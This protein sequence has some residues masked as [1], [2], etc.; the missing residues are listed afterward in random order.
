MPRDLAI[1]D[2]G[3]IIHIGLDNPETLTAYAYLKDPGA[4]IQNIPIDQ[5]DDFK[6]KY[7][8]H[9]DGTVYLVRIMDKFEGREK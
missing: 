9:T 6:R 1:F 8:R 4:A 7:F 3:G 5:R 2:T